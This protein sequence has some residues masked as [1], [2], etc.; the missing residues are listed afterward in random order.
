[1]AAWSLRRKAQQSCMFWTFETS[2]F[3]VPSTNPANRSLEKIKK[4]RRQ[5]AAGGGPELLYLPTRLEQGMLEERRTYLLAKSE[6]STDL[7]GCQAFELGDG[8]QQRRPQWRSDR[9]RDPDGNWLYAGPSRE[10]ARRSIQRT[11]NFSPSG[12]ER[13]SDCGDRVS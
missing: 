11:A 1:M 5:F 6:C 3:F 9:V 2:G 4:D 8:L 13:R 10:T 7:H 12:L